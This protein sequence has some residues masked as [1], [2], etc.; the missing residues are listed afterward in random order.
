VRI[1][2]RFGESG[3]DAGFADRT[4]STELAKDSVYPATLDDSE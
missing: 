4:N 2:N 1:V 3:F